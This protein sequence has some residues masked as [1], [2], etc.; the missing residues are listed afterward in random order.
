MVNTGRVKAPE[1]HPELHEK[2]WAVVK[3]K[4]A[5]V[6]FPNSYQEATRS[7]LIFQCAKYYYQQY[8][9]SMLG[10]DGQH[11]HVGQ[12]P[13]ATMDP[14][15]GISKT[16]HHIA[17][18]GKYQSG[19]SSGAYPVY[20]KLDTV[21]WSQSGTSFG[22]GPDK[23]AIGYIPPSDDNVSLGLKTMSDAGKNVPDFPLT[24]KEDAAESLKSRHGKKK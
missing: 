6:D 22:L 3:D 5:S 10:S 12:A 19:E 20:T 21:A 11:S 8:R 2:L 13:F 15:L 4:Y 18:Q 1:F 23:S 7:F 17:Q 9:D 24:D 14:I 16:S